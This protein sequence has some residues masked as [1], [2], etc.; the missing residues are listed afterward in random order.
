MIL[1]TPPPFDPTPLR[2]QGKLKPAGEPKYAY[3]AMYE[4]YDEVLARYA[5]WIMQQQ[6]AAEMVIDLH[7]PLLEFAAARRKQDPK[8]T[9]SPDGIHPGALGH[10]LIAEE[11]LRAWGAA[12][13]TEPSER[14]LK[15]TQQRLTL[16]HDAWLTHVGHDR[17]GVRPG[18][19]LDEARR[20]ATELEQQIET[21]VARERAPS[22]SR[23]ASTGGEVFQVHYPA[24]LAPGELQLAVDYYLW[25]PAG[26]QQLRGLIV[27]QHGCGVGASLGGRT[28]VDDL[29]WQAL[30]RKWNCGL[31]G[32]SYEPRQ[33]VNCRVWCDPRNGSGDRFEQA[34]A[35]FAAA[36][37]R[38]E[39][40]TVPWCLWGHSGGAFWASLMHVQHPQR[41]I[42]VWLRSG[43]G[44]GAW[45]AGEIAAPKI[46]AAA[47]ETPVT[48]NP[49][50]KEKDDKRFHRAW[51]A[52]TAMQA[53]YQRRGAKCFHFAADPRTGHECGDSRYL[54]IPTSTS[55]WSTACRNRSTG[56][57]ARLLRR[58]TIG[59]GGCPES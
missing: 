26:A 17:P 37:G 28:A 5:R 31:A 40:K 12:S 41:M 2:G 25:I 19:P 16:L 39:V 22:S 27:H 58:S 55:G 36:A 11:I 45:S 57:F 53:E 10:R 34:L 46:P 1:L 29:H 35:Q 43:T 14:L 38:D 44:Y 18:L 49:G 3:F 33:G 56:R 21:L 59:S 48:A 54:A 52:L 32:S 47:Y 15:L 6:D 13:S 20:R 50:L 7:R 4:E 51:D 24:S 23:R 42:A 9:L 30:A 8:F